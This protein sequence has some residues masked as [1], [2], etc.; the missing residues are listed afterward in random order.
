MLFLV[1]LEKVQHEQASDSTEE[2][3]VDKVGPEDYRRKG[4]LC[5][6]VIDHFGLEKNL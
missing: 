3:S 1:E 2:I 4:L 5:E 6:A